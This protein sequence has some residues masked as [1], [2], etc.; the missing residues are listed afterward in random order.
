MD[1]KVIP[2]IVMCMFIFLPV[3]AQKGFY[4]SPNGNDKATGTIDKPFRTLVRARDAVRKVKKNSGDIVVHVLPGTYELK[5]PLRLDQRDGGQDGSRVIYRGS[6]DGKVIISGGTAIRGWKETG[7][8]NVY[9]A[10]I[11][12]AMFRQLYVENHTAIRARFPNIGTYL[13]TGSWDL[14]NQ[15]LMLSNNYSTLQTGSN[16]MELLLLQSWA[17]SYLRIK[18][19]KPTGVGRP[20]FSVVTFQD[21]ETKILFNRPYPSL[22]PTHEFYFENARGFIDQDYEWYH[23][24]GSSTVYCK[25]ADQDNIAEL[26]IVRPVLDTLVILQGTLSEPIKNISFE[27]FTFQHSNWIYPSQH[28]YLNAQAGQ[29]NKSSKPNNEQFILRPPAA[30]YLAN[31]QHVEFKGNTFNN[32]GS[33]AIDFHHGTSSCSIVGNKFT[34]IS[35]SAIAIG[36]FVQ[37][38]D[39]E[40]HIP[41]NPSDKR[42]ISTNDIVSS[43]Y[44]QRAAT[45]YYGCVGIAAG[46]TNGIKISH[47]VLRDL[48]Y[49]GIS[50][51][52]GWTPLPN[53]M[54]NNLIAYND[55]GNVMT[56]MNDGAAIYTLSYQP[57]TK[58]YRNYIHD[59]PKPKLLGQHIMSGIYCDEQ[60]G[61]N[62]ESPLI[63]AEN[64]I[65]YGSFEMIKFHKPGIILIKNTIH[66]QYQKNGQEIIGKVGLLPQF[67]YIIDGQ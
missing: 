43:N 64:I 49:T 46:Y 8:K 56:M 20:Q 14:D 5:E 51:G 57:G 3:F 10:E 65:A 53:A 2:T 7:Q 60:S 45:V 62:E 44:I 25:F 6:K 24:P 41:Y 19:I 9:Q 27:N 11:P 18:T 4:V 16:D 42:E 39:T 34:D 1:C 21:E 66:N 55:I 67:Q 28:G 50:L 58:I 48:P 22:L 63:V 23:D 29:Y 15:T 59:I 38:E 36:K 12:K 31:G 33:T 47:N 54:A 30:V 13:K 32:I 61:G 26:H 37:D 35:G 40:Y 17:E 52:Y